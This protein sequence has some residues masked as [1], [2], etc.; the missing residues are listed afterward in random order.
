MGKPPPSSELERLV[1]YCHPAKIPA[2]TRL[3]GTLDQRAAAHVS[4][5]A[6]RRDR[7]GVG[8]PVER[9]RAVVAALLRDALEAARELR[10]P[11]L[12]GPVLALGDSHTDDL[13]SWAE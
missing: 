1:R 3:P 10:P 8:V 5:G 11:T 7:P 12:A 13:A 9:Y 2:T 6:A 4:R